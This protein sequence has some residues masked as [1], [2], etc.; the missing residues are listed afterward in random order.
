MQN[1]PLRILIAE[2]EA[3]ILF[4]FKSFLNKMGHQVIGE[5]YDGETA[6]NLSRTLSPDLIIMDVKMPNMDGI[7]ALEII[8]DGTTIITPCIFVTAYSDDYLIE[9]AK[10]AGAF[11]YLIK[12]IS[13]ESLRAAID[14]AFIR[15][16]EYKELH[17]ELIITKNN[18]QDRKIIEKAKGLLMDEF[19]FKEQQAMDYLQKK[20]RNTN[21]K[22]IEI[23]KDLIRMNE[24][25][26]TQFNST[27]RK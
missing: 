18:L 4:G 3:M 9:K 23:A 20:S 17:N 1:H 24:T 19:C 16:N 7:K 21:K 6:V 27:N 10:N 22:L 2:D 14:I 11:N 12:P 25:L 8:N 5:A 15:F 13:F 26:G